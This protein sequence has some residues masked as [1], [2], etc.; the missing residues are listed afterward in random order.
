MIR[1]T[2]TAIEFW[3]NSNSSTTWTDHLP[4]SGTVNGV[5]VGGS[6]NYPRNSQWRRIGS[7]GV[8]GSQNVTFNIGNTGTS[9][10]GGP[11]SLT[12]FINRA[13]IPGPPPVPTISNITSTSVVVTFTDGASNG[14]AIQYR[15]VGY[16][17]NPGGA[18]NYA[19]PATSPQ[20]IFGL[21]PGTTYYFWIQN[22]N[23]QGW[24]Y[25]SAR[26]TA[27]TL[28][29]PDAPSAPV[30]SDI[31]QVSAIATFAANGDGGSPITAYQIGYAWVGYGSGESEPPDEPTT[32]ISATPTKTVTGLTPGSTYFFWVRAQNVVG[33]SPWS[34]KSSAR[35]IAGA[36]VKTGSIVKEAIPYV[37]VD[38]VWKLARPWG[39][40]AGVW[41]ETI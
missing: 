36:R 41:K 1:D 27:T 34:V 17:T 2:G 13:S 26:A 18:T 8:S 22:W 6:Y 37:N 11:T 16:S 31:T 38:G 35:T 39:R 5:G 28:K 24:G 40:I 21:E 7:W 4:W 29:V 12:I 25:W 9:G 23:S 19:F 20:N 15:Q 10:F 33:W 30:M 3:I 32:V 14:S